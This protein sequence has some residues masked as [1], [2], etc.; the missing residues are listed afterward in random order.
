MH[1]GNPEYPIPSIKN[2]DRISRKEDK[3]HRTCEHV[4][5][6]SRKDQEG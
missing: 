5:A 3:M 6:V 1:G 2:Q 4:R